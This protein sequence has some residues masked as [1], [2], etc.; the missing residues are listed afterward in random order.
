MRR[1]MSLGED[2]SL[3]ERLHLVEMLSFSLPVNSMIRQTMLKVN[4]TN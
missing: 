4:I 1:E 2:L 3:E